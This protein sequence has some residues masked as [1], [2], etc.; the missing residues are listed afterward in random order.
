MYNTAPENDNTS[1]TANNTPH[2]GDNIR[3]ELSQFSDWSAM[4]F[5]DTTEKW[6]F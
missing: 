3:P 1:V 6:D 4:G 2:G 5:V